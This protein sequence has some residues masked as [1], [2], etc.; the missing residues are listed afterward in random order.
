MLP[1]VSQAEADTMPKR[2]DGKVQVEPYE[3]WLEVLEDKGDLVLSLW[4]SDPVWANRAINITI[5]G[6]RED[7]IFEKLTLQ[8]EGEAG[9]IARANLGPISEL[10]AKCGDDL[11]VDCLSASGNYRSRFTKADET[12]PVSSPVE[13]LLRHIQEGVRKLPDPLHAL[14]W[15]LFMGVWP[16]GHRRTHSWP[17][18]RSGK[19]HREYIWS[20]P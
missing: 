6:D 10:R 5:T 20:T 19:Y 15:R 8:Q 2:Y 11:A 9:Y 3:L 17:R 14:F 4:T 16:G 13:E 1:T 12:L 18:G 7:A